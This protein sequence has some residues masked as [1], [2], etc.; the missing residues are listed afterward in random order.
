MGGPA[1]GGWH[2]MRSF[3]RDASVTEAHLPKGTIKRIARFAAPYRNAI[4][5]FL[6]LV[7]IDAVIG[8]A[9]PWIVKLIIDD[10][11]NKRHHAVVIGLALLMAGL[12]L[13][14]AAV[15]LANRWFSA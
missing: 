12:A 1:G 8:A 10:G 5:A 7:V 13:A 6:V 9:N 14:D 4:V 15:N 2:A 3:R 11:I